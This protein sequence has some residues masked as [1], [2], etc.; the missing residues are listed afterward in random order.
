MTPREWKIG[1]MIK[2]DK[3]RGHHDILCKPKAYN[4]LSDDRVDDMYEKVMCHYII[5]SE[6]LWD[7]YNEK[8]KKV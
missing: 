3:H 7:A 4:K 5:Q 8:N 6:K 2:A 1:Q